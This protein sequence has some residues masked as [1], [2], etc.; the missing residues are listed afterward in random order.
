MVLPK[1]FGNSS[2]K[3][4][5]FGSGNFLRNLPS[6]GIPLTYDDFRG[7]FDSRTL[8]EGTPK[9][10]S[11]DE[12]DLEVTDNGR[13]KRL[14]GTSVVEALGAHPTTQMILHPSLSSS[15][16]LL[17]FSGSSLGVKRVGGTVWTDI[18]MLARSSPVV[19]TLYGEDLIF[20][21]GAGDPYI[22]P[23][24]GAAVAAPLIP[25]A[26]A[27]AT[28][29]GRVFAG[30]AVIEGNYEPMGMSWSDISGDPQSWLGDG[31]NSELLIDNTLPNDRITV[32]KAMGFQLMAVL[33]RN[34]IWVGSFSGNSERPADFALRVVGAGCL[35]PETA[36]VTSVGLIY[37]SPDGVRLFDGN[38]SRI[39][40]AQINKQLLPLVAGQQDD[41]SS[42]YD[43]RRNRYYLFTPSET[44]IYDIGFDRWLRSSMIVDSATPYATQIS[45]P[46]WSAMGMNWSAEMAV[47]WQDVADSETDDLVNYFLYTPGANPELHKEDDT[48]VLFFGVAQTPYWTTPQTAAARL[49]SMV[50][51]KGVLL[52]YTGQAEIEYSLPD[53]DGDFEARPTFITDATGVPRTHWLGLVHTGLGAM[54]KLRIVQGKPEILQFQ[55]IAAPASPRVHTA[56]LPTPGL[57]T[58]TVSGLLKRNIGG[59]GTMEFVL[60]EWQARGQSATNANIGVGAYGI[61]YTAPAF[62]LH[63]VLRNTSIADRDTMLVQGLS[64]GTPANGAMKSVGMAARAQ[65]TGNTGSSVVSYIGHRLPVGINNGA[66]GVSEFD[67]GVEAAF[68]GGVATL[69]LNVGQRSSVYCNPAIIAAYHHDL[70]VGFQAGVSAPGV[71]KP[72]IGF[73]D[74]AGGGNGQVIC[75]EFVACRDRYIKIS[76]PGITAGIRVKVRKADTS[77]VLEDVFAGGTLSLDAWTLLLDGSWADIALF[78][79][80]DVLLRTLAPAGGVWPGDEYNVALL[81]I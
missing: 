76:G 60:G 42:L 74:E 16:E 57:I 13:L 24:G 77:V 7:G 66:H 21:T 65:D 5:S 4:S 17:F 52:E 28:F 30:G 73:W 32:L 45:G 71:G 11:P 27:Y 14:P 63:N 61:A 3:L 54:M 15:S 75:L 6:P 47:T 59:S 78:S 29:A 69:A 48:S 12:L 19:H 72:G 38:N 79:P 64:Y 33:C 53:E 50:E 49:D 34:S 56:P 9:N 26:K 68:N 80:T 36:Q 25:A 70:G 67:A 55:L 20:Y 62:N 22:R 31:G 18:G 44:W 41:Y 39:L 2:T 37:L 35:S 58:R 1:D 10:S 8:A 81:V 43:P 23:T 51:H 40:S 46:L